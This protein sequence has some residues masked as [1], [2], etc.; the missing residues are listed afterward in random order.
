MRVEQSAGTHGRAGVGLIELL[1]VVSIVGIVIAILLPAAGQSRE[2]ARRIQCINNLKQIAL[3]LHTYHDSARVFPPGYVTF[4]SVSKDEK[5]TDLGP[6]W[7]WGSMMLPQV[8]QHG[9]FHAINFE[10][11]VTGFENRT[12]T[13]TR[14]SSR[15]CP[16]DPNWNPAPV[17][18]PDVGATAFL[19]ATSFVGVYGPGR[20]A[21]APGAGRGV[22]FRNSSI[23]LVDLTDG[24][25]QTVLVGERSSEFGQAT[26]VGRAVDG[27]LVAGKQNVWGSGPVPGPE[28]A[29]AMVLGSTGSEAAPYGPG[30]ERAGLSSFNSRHPGGV[31][32]AF[33]DGSVRWVRKSIDPV[34]Y[35]ALSTRSGEELISSGP[36]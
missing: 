16:S 2:A 26:W 25:C 35:R 4:V 11:E 9:I 32:F 3:G 34:I 31:N 24:T 6:G 30:D 5:G 28:E 21:D 19:S 1:V 15:M 14:I 20:I 36:F 33:G 17:Q 7:A 29:W 27:W 10:L 8:E 18:Y 13:N 23:G 22:F 12:A